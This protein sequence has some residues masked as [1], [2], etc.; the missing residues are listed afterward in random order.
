MALS[1]T[2]SRFDK[3]FCT[4][5]FIYCEINFKERTKS[6]RSF[7]HFKKHSTF[8]EEIYL[9]SFGRKKQHSRISVSS[10]SSNKFPQTINESFLAFTTTFEI[11]FFDV[12]KINALSLDFDAIESELSKVAY[13]VQYVTSSHD[14]NSSLSSLALS[15]SLLLSCSRLASRYLNI[16]F[17]NLIENLESSLSKVSR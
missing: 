2:Q 1:S 5:H 7:D 16:P 10:T 3:E 4:F 14:A 12:V 6:H 11:P 13:C 17:L 8:I 9:H 15:Y